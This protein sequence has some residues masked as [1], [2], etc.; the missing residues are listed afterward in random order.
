MIGRIRRIDQ[1]NNKC[2][3]GAVWR[4][5]KNRSA[6]TNRRKH[7]RQRSHDQN[8]YVLH[9]A[10][11]RQTEA[12]LAWPLSQTKHKMRCWHHQPHR[13]GR[14]AIL[15]ILWR[16]VPKDALKRGGAKWN[17]SVRRRPRQERTIKWTPHLEM[18]QTKS[19]IECSKGPVWKN[20]RRWWSMSDFLCE[21]AWRSSRTAETIA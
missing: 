1:H 12:A 2:T 14:I 18:G 7:Q 13:Y 6:P 19:D 20:N 8:M 17:I 3:Y 10:S 5:R 9:I 16:G 4:A 11:L 21:K 15:S